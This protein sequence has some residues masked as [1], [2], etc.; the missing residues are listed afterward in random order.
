MQLLVIG[1]AVAKEGIQE[2]FDFFDRDSEARL[3]T[4][5]LV[6]RDVEAGAMLKILTPLESIPANAH[7]RKVELSEKNYGQGMLIMKLMT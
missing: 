5:V 2:V 3:T 1:E 7:T 6:T 4:K